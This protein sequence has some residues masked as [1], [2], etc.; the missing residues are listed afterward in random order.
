MLRPVEWGFVSRHNPLLEINL[1]SVAVMIFKAVQIACAHAEE[2][3]GSEF[4]LGITNA[5][6]FKFSWIAP[7]LTTAIQNWAVKLKDW[8]IS[9]IKK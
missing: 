3:Q 6:E 2:N 1:T 7:A 4:Y 9:I 8:A 5:S